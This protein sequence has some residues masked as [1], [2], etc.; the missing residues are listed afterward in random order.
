MIKIVEAP[1]VKEVRIM[2]TEMRP[3]QVG[4]L[5]SGT[6]VMR[7]AAEHAFEVIDLSSPGSG[8]CWVEDGA[9]DIEVALLPAGESVTISLFNK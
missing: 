3:L 4:R 8:S 1:K 2:M 6:L 9:E 5:K 7:T